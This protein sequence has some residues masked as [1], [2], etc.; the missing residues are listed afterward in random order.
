[1][2]TL[3]WLRDDLRLAD[4][5]ALTAACSA[6]HGPV[7]ALWI[8]ETR[9]TD[10]DNTRNGPRPLGAAT[11]WWYYRSLQQLAP[12]L[13]NL[14]IPLVFARGDAGKIM[15]R[16]VD[17]LQ[18]TVVH[19]TRRYA[20]AACRLDAAIKQE[21]KSRTDVH[22]HPGSLLAEPWLM[23][24][25]NG[26][27]YQVFTPFS[28]AVAD[29]PLGPLLPEPSPVDEPGGAEPALAS[30]RKDGVL[31]DLEDLGLLDDGPAWWEG[32]LAQHWE[33]G[34]LAARQQLD[35]IDSWL[36]GYAT[37]RDL[38]GEETSTSRISPRL[39]CGELSPRQ[40][41]AAARSSTAA[42]E[43]IAAWTRQL[44]WREFSWH[45]LHHREHLEDTPMRP[46]FAEFPYYPDDHLAQAWRKGSTGI[47]L[48]DAGMR[49]LWQTGWMH[50]RVRM[51]A[52]S[53]FTK[54]MLQPWQDG[55]QWFWETLVD[56]DEA[57][58]PV[59]WQW[60][61]GCGADAAPYFRIF[62]PELQ[63]TR[64]DPHSCYVTRW[65]PE[66]LARPTVP[67]VDLAESRREAL[68]AYEQVRGASAA[69]ARPHRG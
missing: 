1:M 38:P 9:R 61:A 23:Q 15:R 16:V 65:I 49:Q 53:L 57:N 42:G 41:L 44:Y 24:T 7:V 18:P 68:A 4:H 43:D 47:D 54:N 36:P 20:P 25:A 45:L 59:S 62:N 31:Q 69:H 13:D 26:S 48:V 60:V 8:H 28:H 29:L 46:A 21:L 34:E 11:R 17:T 63:R 10:E 39:R 51:V 33:P 30:L 22:S 66:A 35:A 5:P 14:G 3:I 67:V 12:R 37:H 52:A 40:A 55:E 50:N 32:T 64:F 27:H 58:N 56:A 6:A 19:W 2:T